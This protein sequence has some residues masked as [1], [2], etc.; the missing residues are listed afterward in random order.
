MTKSI[1]DKLFSIVRD[2]QQVFEFTQK[3]ALDGFM[4]LN[5]ETPNKIWLNPKIRT[6]LGYKANNFEKEVDA[7]KF[8]EIENIEFLTNLKKGKYQIHL[9]HKQ[10]FSLL[11]NSEVLKVELNGSP[12]LIYA[13]SQIDPLPEV[14]INLLR[15]INRYKK[16]IEGT[17]LGTWQWN[18]QTGETIFNTQWAE[19]I[20]YKL[21]E[22]E[23]TSVETWKLISH[24]EDEEKCNQALQEHFKGRTDYYQTDARVRHKKGHWIWVRDKGKVVSWTENGEPEWMTGFHV[25]ITEE[26]NRLEIK[27]LFI[28][29]APSAIAMFDKEM[30]YIAASQQWKNDYNIADIELEGRRHYDLF[31]NIS[32][33]WKEIHRR[34]L[35]GE[36]HKEAEDCYIWEDGTEQW[37][38]WE[39]K[40]WYTSEKEIGGVIIFTADITKLKI[41]EQENFRKQQLME[42]VLDSID[43]GIIA[44]D[45]DGKLTLFNKATKDWHG[46]PAQHIPQ[47]KLS[48]YYGL[49]SID[50]S[51]QLETSEIPLLKA[52]QNGHIQ[53]EEILIKPNHGKEIKASVNGSQLFDEN[54]NIS[55][56]V[57]AMHDITE[58]VA[59][60]KKLQISEEAFRGSFE[61][62]AIGMA[63][64]D[65]TGKWIKVNNRVCEIVGYTPKELLNLTFHDITHPDDLDLDVKLLEELVNGE[66]D[67]YHMDKRYFHRNGMVVYIHLAVSLVRDEDKNPLY[68]I[69]QITDITKQKIAEEKLNKALIQIEGLLE[70]S[71]QVSIISINNSGIITAFNK[72]AENLLGYSKEEMIGKQTPSIIHSKQEID[73][74]SKKFEKTYGERHEGTALFMALAQ[75]KSYDTRE[76][77]YKRKN[78]TVFPVQLTITAI[79]D[80][81]EIIGYLGVATDISDLKTAQ[82]D[83]T[84]ILK[85]T[86]DQNARLKNFAH[87]VSHNLRSHSGNLGMLLDLYVEDHEDQKDDQIIKML[88]KASS[89]LKETIDHLNEVTVINTN[90][91]DSFS[92]IPLYTEIEKAINSVGA[93]INDA[94]LTIYNEV[95]KDCEIHGIKAYMDSILLNFTTNGIKYRS[96][97]RESFLRFTIKQKKKFVQLII[98]DNGLG[99]DLA[100]HRQKLFG[101]YKTFHN[102][103]DSRGI[104]LFITKNQIE[105]MG[106]KIEVQSE[107]DEGTKFIITLKKYEKN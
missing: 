91:S 70:A 79:S 104:G 68:F 44:C 36:A 30:Q 23:P 45:K 29:Q 13:F 5:P 74:L 25:D 85:L 10:G 96:P 9:K 40:P 31:P 11:L 8:L 39:V 65:P 21:E 101:M 62:A 43:V 4:L 90:E 97:E 89:N 7:E 59:A 17:E 103:K 18:V 80:G 12:L 100:R 78:G 76:W 88:Y 98:E 2:D 26:K 81:D 66:R 47:D 51:H 27:K 38:S 54:G 86:N 28:D 73:A 72:G 33:E 53:N 41:A 34:C 32:E 64:L 35:N 84:N 56:A 22:L 42:T 106:G 52:L 102:N 55:G 67:H 61:H 49:Y 16:I 20:G 69:S 50:G 37:M 58:R 93:L 19:V 87:I 24:P 46:L 63:I 99:I 95:P 92:P 94:D 105:A 15:K 82:R 6:V 83:L 60:E 75:K 71:T 1:M 48:E 14:K 107:V 57:I 3:K 77:T